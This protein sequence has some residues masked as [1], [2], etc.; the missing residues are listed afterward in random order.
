MSA[1]EWGAELYAR[2]TA[3]HHA[4]DDHVLDPLDIARGL[5]GP[6]H[7]ERS[8]RFLGAGRRPRVPD[9]SVLGIDLSAPLV[10]RAEETHR[11]VANLSFVRLGAQ[12]LE[13]LAPVALEGGA[14][15][16]PPFDLVISTATLHWVPAADHPALYRTIRRMLRPGGRFRAEFGGSGQMADTLEVLG[17]ESARLGGPRCPWY[18][19]QPDEIA[20]ALVAAGLELDRGFV[21]L[22]PQLRSV[23]DAEALR[24]W[25]ESQVLIAYRPWLA[26]NEYAQFCERVASRDS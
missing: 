7:R 23:P 24:A 11:A 13:E 26:P 1:V 15:T 21:R 2:N 9:G 20:D 12:Q 25:L 22:V 16:G 14:S 6:R 4:Y 5:A 18:F 3:H 17:E 19:P 8:G 10:G